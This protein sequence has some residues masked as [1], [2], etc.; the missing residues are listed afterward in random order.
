MRV[1]IAPVTPGSLAER[2]IARGC[3]PRSTD[4]V[5]RIHHGPLQLSWSRR[6]GHCPPKAEIAGSSP[7]G[8][9]ARISLAREADCKPAVAR[10][11]PQARLH[12][13]WSRGQGGSLLRGKRAFESRRADSGAH[14]HGTTE[15]SFPARIWLALLSKN[16]SQRRRCPWRLTKTCASYRRRRPCVLRPRRPRPTWRTRGECAPP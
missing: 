2:T 14:V 8:S 12:G 10:F 15:Y 4:T 5:V 16:Q 13:P 9:T 3:K 7:A 11:D 6:I 1:Q